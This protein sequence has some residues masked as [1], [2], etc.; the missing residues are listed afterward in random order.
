M[1]PAR[2]EA[3]L[4]RALAELGYRA[5]RARQAAPGWAVV[6]PDGAAV[7]YGAADA[8]DALI[9]ALTAAATRYTFGGCP[10]RSAAL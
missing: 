2:R 9:R 7:W 5:A 3:R 10:P 6:G 8:E 4:V 1:A